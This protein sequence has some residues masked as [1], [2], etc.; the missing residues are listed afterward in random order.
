MALITKREATQ[1]GQ[2]LYYQW[3]WWCPGCDAAHIFTDQWSFN[4]DE[5]KPT[6]QPSI[7]TSKG[8][9]VRCHVFITD[10]TI[11]YLSDCWHTLKGQTVPMVELPGW[12]ASGVK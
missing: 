3:F 6:V 8:T 1:D 7:L 10:G 2:H 12:L 4:G 9:E 5:Q 11:Q